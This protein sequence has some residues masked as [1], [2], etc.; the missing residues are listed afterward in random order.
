MR[1]VASLCSLGARSVKNDN[2]LAWPRKRGIRKRRGCRSISRS[3]ANSAR[4]PNLAVGGP[5]G[6]S[7]F[8]LLVPD[9]GQS[10][11]LSPPPLSILSS[12]GRITSSAILL[13]VLGVLLAW[14]YGARTRT[15]RATTKAGEVAVSIHMLVEVVASDPTARARQTGLD[16]VVTASLR[17]GVLWVGV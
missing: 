5:K 11:L 16:I 8:L 12:G 2:V 4:V 1:K 14:P 9:I 7:H 15:E 13:N 3:E 10:P 6:S 17:V